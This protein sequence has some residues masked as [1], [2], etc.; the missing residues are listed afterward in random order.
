M[1]GR[2][3]GERG[4]RMLRRSLL[5]KPDGS[6]LRKACY[7]PIT[8]VHFFKCFLLF[9]KN[10]SHSKHMTLSSTEILDTYLLIHVQGRVQVSSSEL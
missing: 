3:L 8:C 7:S 4:N 9:K 5:R 6:Y 1:R 10:S 2:D